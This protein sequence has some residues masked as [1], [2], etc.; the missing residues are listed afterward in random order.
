MSKFLDRPLVLGAAALAGAGYLRLVRATTRF[1]WDIAPAAQ[2]LWDAGDPII[3][4]FWH[5]YQALA[6]AVGSWTR[7][8]VMVSQSRD[9]ELIARV[10]RRF[11][12]TPVRGSSS[13]GGG[14][15]LHNLIELA[16]SGHSVG[17]TPD[18]PRGPLGAV[19]PGVALL[20]RMT[21]LPAVPFAIDASRR[22]VGNGWDRFI[23]PLP[24]GRAVVVAG[25]PFRYEE[26]DGDEAFL[27]RVRERLNQV[28][29]RAAQAVGTE[30]PEALEA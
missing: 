20:A 23:V 2:D 22:W 27:L 16:R 24:L 26:T 14:T 25:E 28:S 19:Q 13:R 5:R 11:G 10:I 15:A 17:I 12:M 9:G 30:L 3:F 7:A 29:R 8:G 1:E 6:C 18:G 4:T 21:R